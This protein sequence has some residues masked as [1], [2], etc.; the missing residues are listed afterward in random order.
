M[1]AATIRLL[2][3]L[4]ARRAAP[5]GPAGLIGLLLGGTLLVVPPSA[6]AASLNDIS[7]TALP[8][9]RVQ[10]ELELSE[11]VTAEPL[12]FTID[13][14][15]RVALDFPA[16]TLKV[17]V[18]TQTI[19]VGKVESVT[20]VEAEGRTRV[21]MN[22]VQVVPYSVKTEG[23]KVKVLLEGV[24]ADI[25]ANVRPSIAGAAATAPAAAP[26]T[27]G[28]TMPGSAAGESIRALD[29]RRG[30]RGEAQI[31]VDLSNP[32][33]GINIQEQGEKLLVDFIGT[34][35]PE[36]L[37]R[38]LDVT[39]FATPAKEIDTFPHGN[40]T[41]MV[42]TPTGLYEHLA[43]QSDN[44]FTL[45]LKPLTKQEEEELK[46][47]KFGYTGERLSLNFQDIEVR[48]VLQ[49]IADFT[50]FN[51]V[52]SDTVGGNVTL[53]LKNVPWDQALDLILKSKNLGKRQNGNVMMIAPQ[54]EIAANEKLEA[55]TKKQLEE[56]APLRTEFIQVNY[57][58]AQDIAT[59]L[60][61][62]GNTPGASTGGATSRS[63]NDN[64]LSPRGSVTVDQRT[65]TLLVQDTADKLTDIRK[66]VAAL[67]IP[68]RQVLIES[69]IVVANE[70][71]SK[72]IGVRFGYSHINNPKNLDLNEGGGRQSDFVSIIGGDI[73]GD[74]DYGGGTAFVTPQGEENYIVNLP[75]AGPAAAFR[76]SI[77]KIGSYLLQLELSAL[78]VEGRGEV[79]ASPQVI[80]ANQKQATIESGTEI[81]Y[82]EATSSGATN[83]SFKKAVLSLQVTPH[84]TPDD[85]V[86]MDLVVN[87][88]SVG[89]VFAGVPSIDTN[90]VNTQVLVEN[91]ET[92]VLGGIF[93]SN[94][95][96][97]VD[98]V[99]FFGDVPYLGHLFKRT[100]VSSEKQ[101]L[102]IFV[103]PKILKESLSLSQR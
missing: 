68:V 61:T 37:D 82:Q 22:L 80:T 64:L 57:A 86:I 69:R 47:E 101:E 23:N 77:G 103:T 79:I 58:K 32:N 54:E 56:L 11:P 30:D 63:R 5:S 55:E 18:K 24:P 43:Y 76:W 93:E 38:K 90:E 100:G 50:G 33:I 9:D 36:E 102:L 48:A 78:Q 73:D 89:Q 70:D 99:P 53:R 31:V 66:L 13:N 81:P 98:K 10:V 8:G 96:S 65:N 49:L 34:R 84:I 72:D 4:S 39:D 46:K 51:L 67:D 16:T 2:N 45:E 52:T 25:T 71:F 42:V 97:D 74:V 21:V 75:V 12:N 3:R 19:G 92:V 94:N 17:P 28:V 29:F 83:V 59:L 60:R 88:D 14:P 40:G 6:L 20:A 1:R 15:A 35:L 91:G 7:Y 26:A 62:R 95:R 41:R 44:T 87:R 27:A 85:R